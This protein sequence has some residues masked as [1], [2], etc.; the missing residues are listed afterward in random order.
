MN[1]NNNIRS[2][3]NIYRES[4]KVTNRDKIELMSDFINKLKQVIHQGEFIIESLSNDINKS[5]NL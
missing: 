4:N 5:S 2:F 3:E 1:R